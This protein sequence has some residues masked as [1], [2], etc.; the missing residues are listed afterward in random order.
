MLKSVVTQ[1]SAAIP[2]MPLYIALSFKKMREEG[3]HE[4]CIEQ[5]N[6]LMRQ[7]MYKADGSAAEVDEA[8][9][10]RLDDWE[11]REVIQKDCMDKWQQVTNENLFEIADYQL[12]KDEFMKLFGFG[13]AG[14]DYEADVNPVVEFD[15]KDF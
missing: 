10:L 7:R 5:I 8:N 4:G 14:V 15:V 6:R 2:V 9:R 3:V 12:Y 13:L 11:L 1:A